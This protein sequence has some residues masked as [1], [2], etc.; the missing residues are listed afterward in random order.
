MKKITFGVVCVQ[1]TENFNY[2]YFQFD[3]I[4]KIDQSSILKLIANIRSIV[5]KVR[6]QQ[7][8]ASF[9]WKTHFLGRN[10]LKV[11][12][13]PPTNVRVNNKECKDDVF[14][15]IQE[16]TINCNRLKTV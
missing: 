3:G 5:Q 10:F 14:P 2:H 13:Y 1:K 8:K 11:N 4:F 9:T 16:E 7:F 15:L 12:K 6:N